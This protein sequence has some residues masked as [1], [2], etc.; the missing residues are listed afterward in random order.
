MNLKEIGLEGVDCIIH[1]PR[2][3]TLAGFPQRHF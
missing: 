3:V 2:Y 1:G